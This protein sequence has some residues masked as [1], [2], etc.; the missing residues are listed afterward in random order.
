MIKLNRHEQALAAKIIFPPFILFALAASF[1]HHNEPVSF[2]ANGIVT[3]IN[4]KTWNHGMPLI[5][6]KQKHL[7]KKFTNSRIT[8]NAQQVEVGDSF[9]KIKNSKFCIVNDIKIQCLN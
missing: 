2:S 4:W 3:S 1:F 5:E 6:I 9:I 7:T 8:L